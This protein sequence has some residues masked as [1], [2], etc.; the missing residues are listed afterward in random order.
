M[1]YL[2]RVVMRFIGELFGI[3]KHLVL[4][5]NFKMISIIINDLEAMCKMSGVLNV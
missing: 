1:S 5:R 2:F 3:G 4:S